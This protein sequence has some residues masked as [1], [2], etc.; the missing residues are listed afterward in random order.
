MLIKI[1]KVD[2]VDVKIPIR[3]HAT[4]A[5]IDFFVPNDFNVFTLRSNKSI[6]IKSGIKIEIPYSYMGLFLNKSSVGSKGLI[7]GAQVIDTFYSNEV[8]IDIHNISD[9]DID[10]LPGMKIAQLVLVPISYAMPIVV[11][12]SELYND[13][14]QQ[15]VRGLNGFGSTN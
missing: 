13:M 14:M 2:N 1:S 8:H 6:L 9:H 10:I 11:D 3:A 4:D 12:E 5:G 7:V 15:E